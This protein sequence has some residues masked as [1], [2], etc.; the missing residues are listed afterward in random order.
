MIVKIQYFSLQSKINM[1]YN[2]SI[3]LSSIQVNHTLLIPEGKYILQELSVF[4]F[5]SSVIVGDSSCGQE[6]SFVM[7][8]ISAELK[9]L[10]VW[11][12]I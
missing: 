4:N 5:L 8:C 7:V 11:F 10:F 12:P 3:K 2:D 9:K 1:Q 6:E